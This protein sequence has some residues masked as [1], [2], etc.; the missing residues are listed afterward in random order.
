MEPDAI[1]RIFSRFEQADDSYARRY[2]GAGLGLSIA[3]ELINLMA[4]TI[5]VE[6]TKGAGS[7]FTVCVP[8][9]ADEKRDPEP[10]LKSLGSPVMVIC[11][12]NTRRQYW[13]HRF[14]GDRLPKAVILTVADLAAGKHGLPGSPD[15]PIYALVD[16]QELDINPADAPELF[17]R[18]SET[19][20][21]VWILVNTPT[22]RPVGLESQAPYKRFRSIVRSPEPA[23][24]RKALDVAYWTTRSE[25]SATESDNDLD[26]WMHQV[27]GLAVL[28]ADDNALNR[29]VIA[30]ML[31]YVQAHI[32]QAR[33]GT[34]ALALLNREPVDIALLDIQMPGLTGV[35]VMHAH[36]EH[37]PGTPVTF[38]ALT[39]D[40]TDECRT[41]CFGAGAVSVLY[42]PVAL[43]SLYHE[44]YVAVT[45]R[46]ASLHPLQ[47]LPPVACANGMLD[48]DL[49]R[50]LE[51]CGQSPDYLASLVACFEHEGSELLQELGRALEVKN[52]TRIRTLLHKLK[53][54]SSS[55]G[56][57]AMATMCGDTLSSSDEQLTDSGQALID[58]LWSLYRDSNH[59]LNRLISGKLMAAS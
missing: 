19:S 56:A 38:I 52:A 43:K 23:D 34:E 48:H 40:T 51:A 50:E 11:N 28:I 9:K 5:S 49:L 2:A 42:K 31:G 46:T 14:D 53:G 36:R 25:Q 13:E 15:S 58:K 27:Q 30:D 20:R 26:L 21:H 39:A 18:S 37:K 24:I 55:I 8:L 16:A 32:L 4:G 7:C 45:A 12:G 41:K 59:Q 17:G 44:L 1:D 22:E 29:R 6:S 3:K 57:R 47:Q 33:D 54:M 10:A 35:E